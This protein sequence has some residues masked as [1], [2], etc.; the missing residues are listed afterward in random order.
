MNEFDTMDVFYKV[1]YIKMTD[2]LCLKN[3]GR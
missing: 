2:K 1:N 3:V